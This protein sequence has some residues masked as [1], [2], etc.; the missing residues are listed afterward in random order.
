[1]SKLEG[2]VNEIIFRLQLNLTLHN[3]HFDFDNVGYDYLHIVKSTSLQLT[4]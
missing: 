4:G 2:R 1:M 3:E